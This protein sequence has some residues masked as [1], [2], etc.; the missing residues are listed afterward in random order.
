MKSRILTVAVLV[1]IVFSCAT[2]KEA[3]KVVD[4]VEPVKSVESIPVVASGQS[5]Y[6]KNCGGCHKL[7]KP[8]AFSKEDWKP[9]LVRMQK[10]AHL[11][12]VDMALISDYISSQL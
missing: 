9:I 10:K 7:Y 12:D 1:V 2:K 6:D 3:P 5:L 4:V 11:D 8:T